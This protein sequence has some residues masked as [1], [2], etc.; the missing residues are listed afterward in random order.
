[1]NEKKNKKTTYSILAI[2][3]AGTFNYTEYYR[4]P[5]DEI[6][7]KFDSWERNEHQPLRISVTFDGKEFFRVKDYMDLCWVIIHKDDPLFEYTKDYRL[8]D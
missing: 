8:K 3:K 7:E 5:L 2:L 6:K 1:M 4:L